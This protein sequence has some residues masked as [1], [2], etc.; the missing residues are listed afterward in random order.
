M[1][2]RGEDTA[3]I[4]FVGAIRLNTTPLGIMLDRHP[5][6]A[7][8]GDFDYAVSCI[9]NGKFPKMQDYYRYLDLE[10]MY[11]IRSWKIYPNYDYARLVRSFLQQAVDRAGKTY[12]GATVRTKFDELLKIW[13]RA[14]FIHLLR[15]PRDVARGYMGMGWS[16]N[17]WHGTDYWVDTVRRWSTLS[18]SLSDDCQLQVRHEDLIQSPQQELSRICDF[19]GIHY[20]DGMLRD[21]DSTTH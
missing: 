19:I 5:Q 3:P 7:N 11:R 12:V 18:K 9:V 1:D 16:G 2:V 4:F 13:P 8:V 6:F 17:V 21:G 14:R 10:H 20:D 15:D